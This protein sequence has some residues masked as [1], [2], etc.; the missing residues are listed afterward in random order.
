MELLVVFSTSSSRSLVYKR[1]F[2]HSEGQIHNRFSTLHF[3]SCRSIIFNAFNI[4]ETM[5]DKSQVCSGFRIR[6]GCN[7]HLFEQSMK[8][9][10]CQ[11]HDPILAWRAF[12]HSPK[13]SITSFILTLGDLHVL[14]AVDILVLW[15]TNSLNSIIISAFDI[16][17][18]EL[19][20][21]SFSFVH[22]ESTFEW[23]SY[24]LKTIHYT[25]VDGNR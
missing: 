23:D 19:V 14:M 7:Y 21:I 17:W 6:I 11:I 22:I 9:K 5:T 16:Y 13:E 8:V 24:S 2:I 4:H 20:E 1:Q 3:S 15:F 10:C 12:S 25:A 18:H